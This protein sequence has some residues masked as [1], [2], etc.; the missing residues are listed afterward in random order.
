M[1]FPFL[2]G[3]VGS[4]TRDNVVGQVGLMMLIVLLGMIL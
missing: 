2:G 4:G 1:L 3:F